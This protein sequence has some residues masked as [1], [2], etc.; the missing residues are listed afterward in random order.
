M[1]Q[2]SSTIS[3]R[4]WLT[5]QVSHLPQKRIDDPEEIELAFYRYVV[6]INENHIAHHLN[7][8]CALLFYILGLSLDLVFLGCSPWNCCPLNDKEGTLQ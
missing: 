1:P 5:D 8:F 4:G 2:Y 7:P 3:Q 6:F